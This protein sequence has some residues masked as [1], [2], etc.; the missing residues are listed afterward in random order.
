MTMRNDSFPINTYEIKFYGQIRMVQASSPRKAL[1]LAIQ[2][3]AI[4]NAAWSWIKLA[5][6]EGHYGPLSIT[7][8]TNILPL[9]PE[10]RVHSFRAHAGP[11]QLKLEL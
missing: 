4:S 1:W 5:T 6:K 8:I 7:K 11:I 3:R 2:A 9:S 10:G